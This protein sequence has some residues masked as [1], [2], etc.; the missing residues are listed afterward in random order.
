MILWEIEQVAKEDTI[1]AS[2]FFT[3]LSELVAI[4]IC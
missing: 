1:K 2:F 4:L 3:K